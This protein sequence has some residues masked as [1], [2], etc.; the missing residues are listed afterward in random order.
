MRCT[1]LH[2]KKGYPP[3]YSFAEKIRRVDTV[4]IK[5]QLEKNNLRRPLNSNFIDVSNGKDRKLRSQV[6]PSCLHSDYAKKKDFRGERATNN[7]CRHRSNY[8]GT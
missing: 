5:Y 4:E 8:K 7:K 1:A 2:I 3:G 6:V